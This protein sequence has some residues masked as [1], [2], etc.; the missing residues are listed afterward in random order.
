[1]ESKNEELRKELRR[2]EELIGTLKTDYDE[3][4][5][6]FE[7][8]KVECER[9]TVEK[10]NE[11]FRKELDDKLDDVS[12]KPTCHV[13]STP[14]SLTDWTCQLAQ[15]FYCKEKEYKELVS[16][17]ENELRELDRQLS[18]RSAELDEARRQRADSLKKYKQAAMKHIESL[19]EKL[20]AKDDLIDVSPLT[21][22]H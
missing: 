22:D 20:L 7:A 12:H 9:S 5:K 3:L 16:R 15:E 8:F 19:M 11:H 21:T 14:D 4:L 17:R 18:E 13:T 6:K 10:V 1:M 2:K